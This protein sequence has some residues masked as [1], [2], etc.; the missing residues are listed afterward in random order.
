MPP[1]APRPGAGLLRELLLDLSHAVSLVLTP[2]QVSRDPLLIRACNRR[3]RGSPKR[4][5]AISRPTCN[6][7]LAL[8]PSCPVSCRDNNPPIGYRCCCSRR[9]QLERGSLKPQRRTRSGLARFSQT[10]T[11][12]R[13]AMPSRTRPPRPSPPPPSCNSR[14]HCTRPRIRPTPPRSS[15]CTR[16]RRDSGSREEPLLLL[17]PLKRSGTTRR[18]GPTCGHWQR[19]RAMPKSRMQM[20]HRRLKRSRRRR[21]AAR[22]SCNRPRRPSPYPHPPSLQHL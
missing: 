13:S 15:A 9:D 2:A 5:C 11:S 19:G 7:P 22:H 1:G 6:P 17:L 21:V 10:A 8:P 20:W 4:S 16:R 12:T 18:S 3:P 14:W